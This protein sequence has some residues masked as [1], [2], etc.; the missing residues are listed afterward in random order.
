M[1]RSGFTLVELLVVISIIAILIALLLPALAKAK[2]E[3]LSVQCASNLKSLG[4]ITAEYTDTYDGFLPFGADWSQFIGGEY[5]SIGPENQWNSLLFAFD[6]GESTIQLYDPAPN[7]P[8]SFRDNSGLWEHYLAMV[9]CPSA[10]YPITDVPTN[11]WA[12]WWYLPTTYAAN[13]NFFIPYDAN[14]SPLATYAFKASNIQDPSEK[15]ALGDAN[16]DYGAPQGYTTWWDFS[17]EQQGYFQQ[18]PNNLQAI[19]DYLVPPGGFS[20]ANGNLN[21]DVTTDLGPGGTGLRY[22]HMYGGPGTGSANVVF[23]DGHVESIP[24][25]NNQTGAQPGA[26]GTTGNRGLRML[27]IINPALPGS[28]NEL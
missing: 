4:Q 14:V 2:Q 21:S 20:L 11:S 23:F 25:N 15:V 12:T 22:R 17:W 26:S 13:P 28:V 18:I 10:A 1:K 19:P 7:V 24:I 3:A 27:N 9:W 8:Q 16:Q 5:P 6:S